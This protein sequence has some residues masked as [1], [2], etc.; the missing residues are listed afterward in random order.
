MGDKEPIVLDL[1][2][3]SE[4]TGK[5]ELEITKAIVQLLL[6]KAN[7]YGRTQYLKLAYKRGAK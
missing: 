2:R 4:K 3:A 6:Y 5:S 1:K 7:Y